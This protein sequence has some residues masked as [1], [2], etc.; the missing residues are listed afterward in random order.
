MNRTGTF[1]G[2]RPSDYAAGGRL[3]RAMDSLTE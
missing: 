1:A 3:A 2:Y